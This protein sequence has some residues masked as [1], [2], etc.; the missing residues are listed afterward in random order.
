MAPDWTGVAS[1][2]P[3]FSIARKISGD[4]PS[5][6][7]RLVPSTLSPLISIVGHKPFLS[8]VI[9]ALQMGVRIQD[10][11]IILPLFTQAEKSR[12]ATVGKKTG[13]PDFRGALR[14]CLRRCGSHY[15]GGSLRG[16]CGTGHHTPPGSR[17]SGPPLC[18]LPRSGGNGWGQYRRG[19]CS[20]CWPGT[21]S[22]P[23]SPPGRR[24]P[25]FPRG[26]PHGGGCGTGHRTPP[27]SRDSGPP[28]Y[29]PPR[30]G[31]NGWDRYRQGQCSPCWPG[32][33]VWPPLL[34]RS[35]R[36]PARSPPPLSR[37]HSRTAGAA[38]TAA[39]RG[40][41]CF[42]ISYPPIKNC[43]QSP[44]T[45]SCDRGP[46]SGRTMTPMEIAWSAVPI[47][48]ISFL[49]F[50]RVFHSPIKSIARSLYAQEGHPSWGGPPFLSAQFNLM[51]ILA[52]NV[53]PSYSP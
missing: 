34:W 20:P 36:P 6:S 41:R 10:K 15:D 12:Q 37:C 35:R 42:N 47:L 27:G 22:R 43:F 38:G 45:V 26:A 32:I 30:S 49:R 29:S 8:S 9:S 48:S 40:L 28:R 2:Y 13:R 3:F 44:R 14:F 24:M 46:R 53:A 33:Q 18:T 52:T 51:T 25:L 7:Y 1:T 21:P 19:Q 16:G 5:S 39:G 50:L 23:Q 4:S 31:G 17:G 11:C